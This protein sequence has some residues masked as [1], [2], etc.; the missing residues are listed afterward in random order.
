MS[1]AVT[2]IASGDEFERLYRAWR[3]ARA[4]WDL[5]ENH[6][7]N[8]DGLTNEEIEPF[9]D[10][11]HAALMAFLLHPIGDPYQFARKLA[12]FRDEEG[13]GFSGAADIVAQLARDARDVAFPH[14]QEVRSA[15]NHK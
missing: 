5:A 13:W 6:P 9:C 15:P 8:S 7:D 12:V 4:A 3:F 11:E 14:Y 10:A 2:S 1:A